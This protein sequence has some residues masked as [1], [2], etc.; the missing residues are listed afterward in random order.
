MLLIDFAQFTNWGMIGEHFFVK[1]SMFRVNYDT[2][3]LNAI[4]AFSNNIRLS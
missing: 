4:V 1:M 2:G 3:A